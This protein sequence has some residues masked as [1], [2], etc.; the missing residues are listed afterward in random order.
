MRKSFVSGARALGLCQAQGQ[1]GAH[2]QAGDEDLLAAGRQV[3]EG[4]L[5]RAVPVLPAGRGQV[6]PGSAVPRQAWRA[7]GEA[8]RGQM[9]SPWPDRPG[10]TGEAMQ[11]KYSDRPAILGERL[12]AWLH[13]VSWFHGALSLAA[14]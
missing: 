2:R 4:V 13:G 10:A 7:D 9:V 3:P 1:A 12:S 8:R 11:D 5:R 14:V 6:L